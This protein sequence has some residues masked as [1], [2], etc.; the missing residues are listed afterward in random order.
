M[1]DERRGWEDG[2][3]KMDEREGKKDGGNTDVGLPLHLDC[4]IVNDHFILH[5][6]CLKHGKKK[7]HV[8]MNAPC[9]LG[10]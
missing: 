5:R 9:T 3:Q 4:I 7:K 8:Y 10:S 2:T 1:N 6:G